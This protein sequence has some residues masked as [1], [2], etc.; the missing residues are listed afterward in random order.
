MSKVPPDPR[1]SRDAK[2]RS[3]PSERVQRATAAQKS[4]RVSATV[5]M[6]LTIASTVISVYDLYLIAAVSR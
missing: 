3:R 4:E 1:R 6:I 2:A 5:V